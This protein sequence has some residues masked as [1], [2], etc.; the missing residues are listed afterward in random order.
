[1][2]EKKL[3]QQTRG[4][5]VFLLIMTALF[6]TSC[7]PGS[8]QPEAD[9]WGE[10]SLTTIEGGNSTYAYDLTF[11]KDGNLVFQNHPQLLVDQIPYVVIAPGRIKITFEQHTDILNYELVDDTLRLF[12]DQG[13]MLYQ[14][15]TTPETVSGGFVESLEE[16]TQTA[17]KFTAEVAVSTPSQKPLVD[18]PSPIPSITPTLTP[19][20]RI[21]SRRVNTI[22]QAEMVYVPAGIF[23]MGS[24]TAAADRD[25]RPVRDVFLD[26]YWIYAHPVTN[27]QF[28][29]FVEQT[30]FKTEAEYFGR[31]WVFEFGSRLVVGAN[32]RAP[33]GAGSHVSGREDHPAVHIS[34]DDAV[35][36]CAWAG[37]RL[38]SEAEC[39]KAARGETG[40]TYPWVI[41]R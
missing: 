16:S 28:S 40:S 13:Y 26:D 3:I 21:G 12:F 32:W 19:T 24:E 6:Y 2:D 39:E 18:T 20:F 23:V 14:R 29:E 22:D 10:W 17:Q 33:E 11:G 15:Q 30:G 31:S 1:M 38:P 9:L 5:L 41:A 25:E 35:V 27:R 34:Y 7:G 8:L 37:G 36:Y 4:I